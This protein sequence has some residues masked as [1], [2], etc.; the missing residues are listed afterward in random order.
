MHDP[1]ALPG[2]DLVVDGVR[3]HVVRHGRDGHQGEPPL[4]MLHGLGT[5]GRLWSD[6]ARDLERG[7][8]SIVPDLA[9][10]GR[11]ERPDRRRCAPTA[12]A[13]LMLALLS[14]LQHERAVVVGHDAGG[15]VAVHIAALAPERVSA[16]VLTGSPLHD[17][18]WPP[19]MALPLRVPVL[20][21]VFGGLLRY[22]GPATARVVTGLA[23]STAGGSGPPA[24]ELA[25]Y[26]AALAGPEA[27]RGL[28]DFV[29]S[30]DASAVQAAL[31]V[32][33]AAAPPTLVLWGEEDRRLPV[34]YGARVA[35]ALPGATWVPIAGAGHLLP[36][37]RPERV[38]EEIAGFLADVAAPVSG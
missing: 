4:L 13:E 21:S 36:T 19:P 16:L 30:F 27:G 22:A 12:Q 7:H 5:T 28:R 15:A 8:R 17:D 32:V 2:D 20:G 34:T 29:E 3:L 33:A 10:C 11:S 14:E 31:E 9:G 35:A 18:V 23:G 26:A 37:E 6:V 1:H 38:A 24:G 25:A